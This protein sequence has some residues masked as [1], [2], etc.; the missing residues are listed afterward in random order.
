MPVSFAGVG[1]LP[2]FAICN[3][4]SDEVVMF[5]L[6]PLPLFPVAHPKPAPN[7]AIEV[8]GDVLHVG[9]AEVVHPS[10]DELVELYNAPG[11]AHAVASQGNL[12][13]LGFEACGGLAMD[14]GSYLA[15]LCVEGDTGKLPF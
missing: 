1:K 5:G 6:N 11:H 15:F 4:E 9:D 2:G 7:P 13:Y 8:A 12:S 10:H 3:P 14:E